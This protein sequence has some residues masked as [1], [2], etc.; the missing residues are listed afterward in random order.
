MPG[1][2]R[3]LGRVLA[4]LLGVTCLAVA[5]ACDDGA[6]E[7]AGRATTTVAETRVTISEEGG[8][9]AGGFDRIPRVVREV[10]ASVVAVLTE[11]GEGSGV[12]WAADG[13]VVTNHHVAGDARSIEVGFADGRRV[14]ATLIATDPLTDLAVL[15]AER[16]GLPAATFA[17]DLPEVGELA[18]AMGNP[19]GFE[20]TVTAGI[21]SGLHR[22]IPGSAPATQALV[23]LI[24]TDAAISPGNSGGALLNGD[25]EVIGINV[26][27]LP[28]EARAVSI[29]FAIPAATVTDVVRQLLADGTVS[30]AFLGVVPA[31]LT[32]QVARQLG[33]TAESGVIVLETVADGPAAS[34]G[35]TP[36]DVIVE[37]ADEPIDSVEAFLAALRQ[38]EPGERITVAVQRGDER[39]AF[40]VTLSDR[41][42]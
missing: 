41:P 29:G 2:L 20:N 8:S 34:A 26:A 14:P 18:I 28:P 25:G 27:Y 39:M 22:S 10:E 36:G 24:Q 37:I 5:A 42:A 11:S 16:A 31:P 6:G 4:Q 17:A 1:G 40:D 35:L 33:V 13:V 21:I 38:H 12:V 19:L 32:P 23:D 3:H 7:D 15:R 9:A 30:H